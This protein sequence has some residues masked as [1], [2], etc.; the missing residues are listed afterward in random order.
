MNKKQVTALLCIVLF[1]CVSCSVKVKKKIDKK[2]TP[3][4][5]KAEIFEE[6]HSSYYYFIKSRLAFQKG[7]IND[8]ILLLTKAIEKDPESLYLKKELARIYFVHKDYSKAEGIIE[9]LLVQKPNN[10]DILIFQAKLRQAMKADID[11]I[12][13]IY[14]K[15]IKIDP[16][17]ENVYLML[18][19]LYMNDDDISNA[20]II[21]KKLVKN[22]PSSF[23][24]HFFLGKIN[25]YRGNYVVAEKELKK[26]IKLNPD[27]IEPYL[28]LLNLY[29]VDKPY[30]ETVYIEKGDSISKIYLQLF[31]R[32]NDAIKDTVIEYNPQLNSQEQ[33]FQKQIIKFP[34]IGII[35]DSDEI[36][37][38]INKILK[39]DPSNYF[40]KMEQGLLYHKLGKTDAKNKV[41]NQLG[42]L[43]DTDNMV[44]TTVVEQYIDKRRNNSA[45][46]ILKSMNG[47]KQQNQ[48]YY[49]K[50]LVDI[51]MGKI[52]SAIKQ[53]LKIDK[54]S[55]LYQKAVVH[56]SF[57]YQ[58][59]GENKKAITCLEKAL[60]SMGDNID[61][62]YYLSSL[63]EEEKM[64]NK[65]VE[66]LLKGVKYDNAN[67][68]LHFRLGIVFDKM[69]QK[70]ECIKQLE[71][72]IQLE[73]ENA[74]ALNYLG[75]TLVDIGVDL[76]KAQEFIEKAV[77]LKPDDGYIID[78]LGWL[79]YKKGDYKKA[80]KF[81]KK[82]TEIIL[83]DPLILEHLGDVYVKILEYQKAFDIYQLAFEQNGENKLSLEK[84]INALEKKGFS[85]NE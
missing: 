50:A 65:A 56:I 70:Q 60:K 29:T 54:K 22:I 77:S 3:I 53:L 35:K 48:I 30:F 8:A 61:F 68:D 78:S 24:G 15:I 36:E 4:I 31:E 42:Q 49:L 85:Q 16:K 19:D 59:I 7:N 52:N 75:Y 74:S 81:L 17:M 79:Y 18:C 55:N 57:L 5:S 21:Y 40:A 39:I 9:D 58:D 44:L 38:L 1:V 64:Y 82:A 10:I 23:T 28:E 34:H 72:V 6:S 27:H 45:M 20:L 11:E 66:M 12:K 76:N 63:Y 51:G 73:P 37:L 62:I 83:N 47:E 84:K 71:I 32:Y 25:A 2:I 80:V 43:S 69:G 41:F 33:I 14:E 13:G 67:A 46:I 26:T